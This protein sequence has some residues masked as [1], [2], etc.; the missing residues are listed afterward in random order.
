[1]AEIIRNGIK[2]LLFFVFAI[3]LIVVLTYLAYPNWRYLPGSK[4]KICSRQKYSLAETVRRFNEEASSS[5]KIHNLEDILERKFPGKIEPILNVLPIC[6]STG[7]QTF[8]ISGDLA[9]PGSKIFCLYH[10]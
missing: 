6:P 8:R 2:V 4:R 5:Q 9:S 10:H 1:M 7:S 3:G